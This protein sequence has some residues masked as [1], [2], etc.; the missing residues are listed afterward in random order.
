MMAL[1]RPKHVETCHQTAGNI[2]V[3]TDGLAITSLL[4]RR[5]HRAVQKLADQHPVTERSMPVDRICHP[6]YFGILKPVCPLDIHDV[7]TM[8]K[9]L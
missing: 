3:V 4:K 8:K 9:I 1:F 2:C 5:P 6:H 7:E